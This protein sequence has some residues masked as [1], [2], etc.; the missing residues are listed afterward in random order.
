MVI[1]MMTLFPLHGSPGLLKT[2]QRA[3]LMLRFHKRDP[4]TKRFVLLS[5]VAK[6][7][8]PP[9]R[10]DNSVTSTEYVHNVHSEGEGRDE[11]GCQGEFTRDVA[12]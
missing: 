10:C 8:C 4:Q 5:P 9:C 3:N 12:V 2:A 11:W 6:S 7:D 1:E